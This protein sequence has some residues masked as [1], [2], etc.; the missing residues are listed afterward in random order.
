[1]KS[2]ER[3]A[4]RPANRL[5]AVV[6]LTALAMLATL[7]L[8]SAGARAASRPAA[9]TSAVVVKVA[10]RGGFGKILTTVG[11]RTLYKHPNGP[12][13]GSCLAI[14]PPLLMPK[15]KTVPR[16][17]VGLRTV[18][19]ASGRRQVT[20]RH[21]RLYTFVN[22]SGTSVNGNGIAG[23]LVAKVVS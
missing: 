6:A 16:G 18:L 1:M 17:I 9:S 7:V 21:R 15:G 13:T 5:W 4:G 2:L 8:L 3:T 20:Y 14:W 12:C 19:L 11:G 10:K 23:F 22:D